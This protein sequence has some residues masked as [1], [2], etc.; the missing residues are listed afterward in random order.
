MTD[1]DGHHTPI[2]SSVWIMHRQYKQ[3]QKSMHNTSQ[4]YVH[5]YIHL[6]THPPIHTSIHIHTYIHT[7]INDVYNHL[8][9]TKPHIN[10]DVLLH[11]KI[12]HTSTFSFQWEKPTVIHHAS[13]KKHHKHV[14][15]FIQYTSV[16]QQSNH[17]RSLI[18]HTSTMTDHLLKYDHTS[19]HRIS[20][21]EALA[22]RMSFIL[23]RPHFG[24]SHVRKYNPC[25]HW[26]TTRKKI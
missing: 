16:N 14:L 9:V 10:R 11:V 20:E 6:N 13:C 2:W 17:D 7:Y 5:T 24:T 12:Q 4:T 21:T 25:T 23:T 22:H 18:Q 3:A 19:I 8:T 26:Y 15:I 1:L